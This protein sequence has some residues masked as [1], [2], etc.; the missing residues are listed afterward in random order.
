[1]I[2]FNLKNIKVTTL[3]QRYFTK[4]LINTYLT[5]EMT[6]LERT[7]LLTS[8]TE[9]F[10]DLQEVTKDIFEETL[11]SLGVETYYDLKLIEKAFF[12]LKSSLKR[13]CCLEA[14]M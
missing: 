5:P 4:C 2:T 14:E 7:F 13:P 9:V 10:P 11:Q 6:D 3:L 12:G 8:I 1:M